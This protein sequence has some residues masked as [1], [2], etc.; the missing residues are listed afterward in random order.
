MQKFRTT[1][2]AVSL[3]FLTLLYVAQAQ[4]TEKLTSASSRPSMSLDTRISTQNGDGSIPKSSTNTFARQWR[5]TSR[6]STS[7]R[8]TSSISAVPTATAL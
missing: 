5:I 4:T 6:C 2:I 7:I 8:T 1:L 3:G